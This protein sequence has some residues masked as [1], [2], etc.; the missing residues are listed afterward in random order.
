MYT[1]SRR[2]APFIY[3]PYIPGENHILMYS[4]PG[5]IDIA[6]YTY[7]ITDMG[8]VYSIA[9]NCNPVKKNQNQQGYI[10]YHLL[11]N[12][13]GRQM[14]K[15]SRLVLIYFKYF[16]GCEQYEANHI[17]G[18]H[19]DNRLCNLEWV[20][21]EE[22]IRHSIQNRLQPKVRSLSNQEAYEIK[23]ALA[24]GSMSREELALKYDTTMNIINDIA[25]GRIYKDV[26]NERY[27]D[28]IYRDAETIDPNTVVNIYNDLLHGV[29]EYQIQEQYGVS[30]SVINCIR[31]AHPAYK[32]ALMN[33]T[34]IKNK[35][36]NALSEEIALQIY[37][38]LANGAT[39]TDTAIKY[40][41]SAATISKIRSCTQSFNYL[42]TKYG[43][44]PL[45]TKNITLSEET[46]VE[47]FK[48]AGYMQ[49]KEIAQ[50]MGVSMATIID[51][52]HCKGR[53]EFLIHKYGFIPYEYQSYKYKVQ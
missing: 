49:V 48:K 40:S 41:L 16:P 46:V 2:N 51:I 10:S 4:I 32:K 15:A 27:I 47:I 8:N 42:T 45:G 35:A 13:S 3:C 29:E 22:N 36:L 6:E 11:T 50:E 37:N 17:N 26:S 23:C 52:K 33:R 20:T 21:H 43:L 5:V 31:N 9:D 25:I 19:D 28:Q 24:D 44:K 34:A 39:V 30:L 1:G 12:Y 14:Y 7:F 38:E 53:Y 18:V